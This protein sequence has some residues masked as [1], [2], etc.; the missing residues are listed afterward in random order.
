MK[1]I[2]RNKGK[3][4]FYYVMSLNLEPPKLTMDG[5]E[6]QV[7]MDIVRLFVTEK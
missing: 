5:I 1:K 6:L 7:N 2:I 3:Y 4:I